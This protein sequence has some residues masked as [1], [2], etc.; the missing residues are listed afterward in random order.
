LPT[1]LRSER[2]RGYF[3][4]HTWR[5]TAKKERSVPCSQYRPYFN[6]RLSWSQSV[7]L[8]R[9]NAR[10]GRPPLSLQKAAG[11]ARQ[12]SMACPID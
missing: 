6:G 12:H 8:W 9:W 1:N 2:P 11:S 10:C 5:A 7:N 4:R 3:E